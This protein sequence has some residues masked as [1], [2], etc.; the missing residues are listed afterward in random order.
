MDTQRK[1]LR[2]RWGAV[3]SLALVASLLAL[4]AAAEEHDECEPEFIQ[5]QVGTEYLWEQY[6]TNNGNTIN[7][8]ETWA[9]EKPEGS[10]SPP[11]D[12]RKVDPEQSRPL[13]EQRENPEYDP[14]CG[15]AVF[16]GKVTICHATPP[17]TAAQ[18][19]NKQTIDDSGT[20][21]NGHDGHD[22]DII[23]AFQGT[24]AFYPGKNLGDLNM[25]GLYLLTG[26]HVWEADCEIPAEI[27]VCVLDTG[28]LAMVD[29]TM[30]DPEL[31]AAAS[32]DA[33]DD[34]DNGGGGG[35]GGGGSSSSTTALPEELATGPATT[36][37][38]PTE[39][40]TGYGPS[41]LPWAL[42]LTVL[43]GLSVGGAGYAL[44]RH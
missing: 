39:L 11:R 2:T 7:N 3:F 19:W 13:M 4:P 18:G 36:P 43:L 41:A 42:Y 30:T 44:R 14:E 32:D 24:E 16:D 15:D 27:E 37:V 9:A 21:F 31:H 22:M 10:T 34:D 38:L 6:N 40:A 8:S 23:P 28:N 26:V 29:P 1:S 5:V 17:A 33:C 12:Y 25:E 20:S 35:G